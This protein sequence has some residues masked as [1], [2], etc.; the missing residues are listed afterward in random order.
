MSI[1]NKLRGLKEIWKF[2]NHWYLALT[3]LL[4]P[5]ESI[6][7]Y[8]YK[9]LRILIDH[10]AGD[11]NGA[12]EILTSEMYRMYLGGLNFPGKINVLD[13]GANNG[14][15]PLLLKTEGFKLNKVVCV[16][17]NPNTFSRLKFN[18]E[19]NFE[20]KITAL[21]CAVCGASR[22]LSISLGSGSAADNIYQSQ[23]SINT[24]T[25]KIEG[26]TFNE[27]FAENFGSESVAIC[28]M[29]VEG[30][31]FEIFENDN[32]SRIKDCKFLLMEIHHEKDRKR[33]FVLNKLSELNFKEIKG[34]N[35]K[36]DQHYV[37]LFENQ[38]FLFKDLSD[39]S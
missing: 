26:K 35:K 30:A 34:E 10:S 1:S 9:G 33:D 21:N 27:I 28:K 24:K 36:D 6:N 7:I 22:E 39:L 13:L 20:S 25:Y 4:F 23:N 16:E 18:L 38:N 29:D 32:C 31:E 15:F 11:A 2:E 19:A 37:H 5:K 17:L 12:R 8:R 3:R 14:G